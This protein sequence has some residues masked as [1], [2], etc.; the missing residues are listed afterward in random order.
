MEIINYAIYSNQNKYLFGK[1]FANNT[2]NSMEYRFFYIS[3]SITCY[4]HLY[5]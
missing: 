1:R 5:T 3:D 2:V 4:R